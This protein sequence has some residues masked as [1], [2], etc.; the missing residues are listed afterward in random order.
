M[1]L[2][3]LLRPEE[4]ECRI[5][6]IGKD[7]SWLTLLLYKTVRTDASLLDEVVGPYNWAND[8]RVIDGKMYCGI[9]IR[10]DDGEWIWRWNVGTESNTEAEKG[11][12]SDAMKRAGF[13]WGIGAE[14]YSAPRIYLRSDVCEIKKRENGKFVCYDRFAVSRIEYGERE[15][16]TALEIVNAKNGRAV[17]TFGGRAAAP[18]PAT[19]DGPAPG[20]QTRL[21]D[22]DPPVYKCRKCGKVVD[23]NTAAWSR[24]ACEGLILCSEHQRD[25]FTWK[26]QQGGTASA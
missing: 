3:R 22:Q 23:Q 11:E 18:R 7:G 10:S 19:D 13:V 17:Y 1:R 2:F 12:A 25:Y 20:R 9:G 24:E 4:I 14:L 6:E 8:Y 5:S 26:K 21:E 16:I 15:E